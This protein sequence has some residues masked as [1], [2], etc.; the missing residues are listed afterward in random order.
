MN[1]RDVILETRIRYYK[2]EYDGRI[3]SDVGARLK[4]ILLDCYASELLPL[5]KERFDC[6]PLY[7]EKTVRIVYTSQETILIEMY[8]L[9]LAHEVID[10]TNDIIRTIESVDVKRP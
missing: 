1:I 6:H 8:N 2:D 5:L 9:V 3:K 4:V 10:R 7:E